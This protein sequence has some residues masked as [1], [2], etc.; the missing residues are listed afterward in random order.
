M[1]LSMWYT[2]ELGEC[3][4]LECT[5]DH[6]ECVKSPGGEVCICSHGYSGD[7]YAECLRKYTVIFCHLIHLITLPHSVV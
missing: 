6:S 5:V 3:E 7:A 1:T 2:E 4:V